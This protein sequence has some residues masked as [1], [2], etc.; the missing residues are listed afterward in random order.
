MDD[1]SISSQPLLHVANV[2]YLISYSLRDI[3][4]LRVATVL[5]MLCLGWCYWACHENYALAWQSAFLAINLFQIALLIYER[6]PVKLTEVQQKLHEGP[7]S[8]LSPRQV[9]RFADKA[10]WCT[11]EAGTK[12]VE[13]NSNLQHLILM[14]SG[15]ATVIAAGKEIAKISEGQFV[16]EMSFLTGGNATAEVVANDTILYARWEEQYINDLIQRD[17][18]LGTAL[19]AALG[20]DLV[21]KLLRGRASN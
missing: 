10:D 5:A 11:V 19:Q 21:K 15:Q 13:E 9:Q 16:G 2:L 17:R 20:T 14:L 12:L 4:W 7:L 18:D 8:P 1:H 3:L 6:R